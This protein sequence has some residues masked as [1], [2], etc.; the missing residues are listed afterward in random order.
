VFIVSLGGVFDRLGDS[1]RVK[2]MHKKY[3]YWYKGVKREHLQTMLDDQGEKGWDLCGV[4]AFGSM[5]DKELEFVP[6]FKRE[7]VVS[8][9]LSE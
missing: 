2:D 3:E 4:V 7:K 9:D 8:E 5:E 6:F 1:G